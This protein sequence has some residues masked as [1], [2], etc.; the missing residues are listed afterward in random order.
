MNLTKKP[1]ILTRGLLAA[2]LQDAA[3]RQQVEAANPVP[4][5]RTT[6]EEIRKRIG[7]RDLDQVFISTG[8]GCFNA[9]K[10]MRMF[11]SKP[12]NFGVLELPITT[13][14]IT[15]VQSF[16]EIDDETLAGMEPKRVDEPI[17]GVELRD[18]NPLLIIDGH[19]RIVKRW[20]LGLR[21]VKVIIMPAHKVHMIHTPHVKA[22]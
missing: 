9:G 14:L 12:M 20:N 10:M 3:L 16:I 22:R 19:H 5:D 6:P 7:A 1:N 11:M 2:A 15:Y 13:E 4:E 21:T 17:L 8:H 18:V